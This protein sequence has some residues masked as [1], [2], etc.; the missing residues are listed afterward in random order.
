MTSSNKDKKKKK[1]LVLQAFPANNDEYVNDED[2]APLSRKFRWFFT[3]GKTVF[4]ELRSKKT[5]VI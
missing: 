1:D 3:E 5:V 4:L 2:I